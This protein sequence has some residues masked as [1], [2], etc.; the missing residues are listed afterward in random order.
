MAAQTAAVRALGRIRDLEAI[1][2]LVAA[3]SNT[4]T[5]EEAAAALVAFGQPAIPHLV[6]VLK[7]EQDGNIL[8]HV[9]EALALLG[10]RQGRIA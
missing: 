3:L 8:Y 10:W 7:H 6:A 2:T 1:P 4:V 5:R 9:K